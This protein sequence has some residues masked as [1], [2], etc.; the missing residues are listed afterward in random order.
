MLSLPCARACSHTR[1]S[2]RANRSLC[3]S[4]HSRRGRDRDR[5]RDFQLPTRGGRDRDRERERE[6]DRGAR[7]RD[8]GGREV[9]GLYTFQLFPWPWDTG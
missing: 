1:H 2:K 7:E 5:E 4:R 9:S 6:R 3:V 8:Y